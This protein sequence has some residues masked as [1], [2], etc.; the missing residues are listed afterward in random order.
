MDFMVRTCKT[1]LS[2]HEA[3]V[4]YGNDSIFSMFG[5]GSWRKRKLDSSVLEAGGGPSGGDSG[6]RTV[7]R[8]RAQEKQR[9]S[10]KRQLS[11]ILDGST[12]GVPRPTV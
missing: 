5:L 4:D 2:G 1:I 9:A 3:V 6:P 7:Q 12:D 10:M 8:D 11:L